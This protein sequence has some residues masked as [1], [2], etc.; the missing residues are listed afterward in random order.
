MARAEK[1]DSEKSID[2]RFLSE[3]TVSHR[4]TR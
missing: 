1:I 2:R 3:T 4:F